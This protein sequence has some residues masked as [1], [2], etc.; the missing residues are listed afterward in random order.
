[1]IKVEQKHGLS[2]RSS[3]YPGASGGE[4]IDER[5]DEKSPLHESLDGAGGCDL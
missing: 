1:M 3:S 4:G 2:E 5:V